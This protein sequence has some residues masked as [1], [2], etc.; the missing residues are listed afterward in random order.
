VLA[1]GGFQHSSGPHAQRWF[2]VTGV[3]W[4][5]RRTDATVPPG[6]SPASKSLERRAHANYRG[7]FSLVVHTS[8]G[9]IRAAVAPLSAT[10]RSDGTPEPIDPPHGSAQQWDTAA[11]IEQSAYPERPASGPSYIYGHACH[12]HVCPFTRLRESRVGDTITVRASAKPIKY[13]VCATGVSSKAANLVVPTC[14]SST[15]LVLVTC[16]YERGDTST[17]NIVVVATTVE[18]REPTN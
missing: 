2:G 8:R 14:N 5:S 10:I 7:A 12:Y 9:E 17:N 3:T 18:T 16:Q 15:D 13:R 4:S 11:W 1:G 6:A